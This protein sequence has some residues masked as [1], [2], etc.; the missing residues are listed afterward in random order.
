[1]PAGRK[2]LDYLRDAWPRLALELLVLVIGFSLSLMIDRWLTDRENRRTE[3]RTLEHIREN[4][5]SDTAVIANRS[6]RLRQMIHAYDELLKP[7]AADSLPADSID[8]FMDLAISYIAF[9]RTDN[10]YEEMRQTGASAHIRDKPLLNEII[11]LYN[12]E[13]FRAQEWDGIDRG[14]VL[15]RMV[16]YLDDNAP[17]VPTRSKDGVLIGT[18][19]IFRALAPDDRFRNLLRTNR[20]FKEAHL[21]VYDL[22]RA[23]IDSLLVELDRKLGKD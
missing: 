20:L 7:G 5:A 22:T 3:R 10:A 4:L 12:R 2:L 21:G 16:P 23:K 6:A 17:Y 18:A 8:V 15:D 14:F 1:M 9:A 13:Y 19:P 11:N